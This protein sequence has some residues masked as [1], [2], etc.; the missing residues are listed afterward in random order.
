MSTKEKRKFKITIPIHVGI[1]IPLTVIKNRVLEYCFKY[2]LD[3]KILQ[4]GF[5]CRDVTFLIS[6][7]DTDEMANTHKIALHNYFQALEFET[8]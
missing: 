5:F 1:L 6:G 8:M 3:C 4:S 7:E 2:N